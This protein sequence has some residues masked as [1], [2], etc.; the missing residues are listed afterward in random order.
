MD[1]PTFIPKHQRKDRKNETEIKPESIK[2]ESSKDKRPPSQ[3][4]F[5]QL[6][7]PPVQNTRSDRHSKRLKFEWSSWEDTST[8][9]PAII[10][11]LIP[12]PP[13]RKD[14]LDELKSIAKRDPLILPLSQ[15]TTNDWRIFR[16]LQEIHVKGPGEIAFPLRNWEEAKIMMKLKEAIVNKAGYDVPTAIQQQ[17]I[18]LIL[19]GRDL[20]GLAETG[21]GK[22]AA[23]VI[24]LIERLAQLPPLR[25]NK[26]QDGPYVLIVAPTRELVL[27]ITKE[28]DK[29][30]NLFGI[31][32]LSIIGGHSITEQS[33][34]MRDGVEV[35]VGT[36]GR[37]RDCYEQHVLSLNQCQ[38]VV[39]D[40]ADRMVEGGFD[41]D[42]HF[43]LACIQGTRQ[44]AMFTATMPIK[45]EQLVK[46]YLKD[47]ITVRVGL[48]SG[49]SYSMPNVNIQ[50][51]IELL[52][53]DSK[54]TA[55]LVEILSD[56]TT[57]FP[58]IVFANS[59]DTVD[60][61]VKQLGSRKQ[62]E[63]R[64]AVLHGGM[65]Q[66]KRERALDG[67]R[68]GQSNVL[69]ATDVAGRGLDVP[70]VQLVI[71]YD[72]PSSL[73]TYL[74]R[75]GRTGR[76]GRCGKAITFVTDTDKDLFWELRTL[77]DRSEG[78]VK[79]SKEF[80]AHPST[81]SRFGLAIPASKRR[82]EQIV[83]RT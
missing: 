70:E 46:R 8:V 59:R 33:M 5:T 83:Y 29:F 66:D 64:L 78:N 54:K 48:G 1:K 82:N 9:E 81:Q 17:T 24:P 10:N 58:I 77:L 36:P 31:R 14:P 28:F 80:L 23:F 38:F 34:D 53:G 19:Q 61:L 12:V 27:Q 30:S 11:N 57:S 4:N 25:G 3:Q 47:Y 16:E 2:L 76:A 21:S 74:H 51:S 65:S 39:L 15:M 18:P 45:I 26:A 42:L 20:L 62:Q 35:I 43:L 22:T 44:M 49:L 68:S 41:D 72:M 6:P 52:D 63:W 73:Q 67:L 75:I 32:A 55:R 69:V 56:D 60:M 13:T 7:P 40:E 79:M 37:L 71:N 50:Q